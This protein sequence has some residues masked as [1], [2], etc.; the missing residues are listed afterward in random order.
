MAGIAAVC[1]L[2]AGSFLYLPSPAQSPIPP[3]TPPPAIDVAALQA[4]AEQGD[5]ESQGRLGKAFAEGNGV[6]RNYK[7]A[8]RWYGLAAS[9][10]NVEAEAMLGELCQAG[11]GV[12]PR[13][14][15]RR[16][17]VYKRRPTREHHCAIRSCVYVRTRPRRAAR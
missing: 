8:A 5:A 13:P 10:G 11:Q 12:P 7:V 17:L 6:K 1:V 16:P 2:I 4:K 9:N 15:K 3:V 14:H